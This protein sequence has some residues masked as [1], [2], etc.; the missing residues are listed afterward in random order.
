MTGKLNA[1]V[2]GNWSGQG[3]GLMRMRLI[4]GNT[5][6]CYINITYTNNRIRALKLVICMRLWSAAEQ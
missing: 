2:M 6:K 4:K 5:I 3:E 1:C